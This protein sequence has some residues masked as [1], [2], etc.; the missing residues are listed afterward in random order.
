MK[1]NMIKKIEL[2][3]RNNDSKFLKLRQKKIENW[4][5]VREWRMNGR[6][7]RMLVLVVEEGSER[8]NLKLIRRSTEEQ[9]WQ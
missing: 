4:T 2:V 5:V 6:S 9:C 8:A 7:L 1:K 3:V